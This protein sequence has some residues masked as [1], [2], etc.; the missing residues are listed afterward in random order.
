MIRIQL[1]DAG[2]LG[3][4][5]KSISL[6][7][8]PHIR[9]IRTHLLSPFGMSLYRYYIEED[10][11]LRQ[12]FFFWAK[13]TESN[14]RTATN[15]RLIRETQEPSPPREPG[16]ARRFEGWLSGR[17]PEHVLTG[18]ALYFGYVAPLLRFKTELPHHD[19]S[20]SER[21]GRRLIAAWA[22]PLGGRRWPN[23]P[24]PSRLPGVHAPRETEQHRRR[25]QSTGYDSAPSRHAPLPS[26]FRVIR[27]HRHIQC[28]AS[29]FSARDYRFRIFYC[30]ISSG[31]G[32]FSALGGAHFHPSRSI[33]VVS[34]ALTKIVRTCVTS[35][36]PSFQ[37]ALR[38]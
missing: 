37:T 31:A 4:I 28:E 10:G 8:E 38:R 34:P 21:I 16:F 5:A 25:K 6:P 11:S 30:G 9:V 12:H 3:S 2:K 22:D 27:F 32:S 19:P 35:L 1:G 20:P 23:D 13:I 17:D 7:A 29:V 14:G 26:F 36:T 24:K 15:L 18:G 33:S